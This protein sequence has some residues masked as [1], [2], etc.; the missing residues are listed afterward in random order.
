[1]FFKHYLEDNVY[2]LVIVDDQDSLFTHILSPL[3]PRA[4][5][6]FWVDLFNS[7][8]IIVLS[9]TR[10]ICSPHALQ[11]IVRVPPS[12]WKRTWLIVPHSGHTTS[13]FSALL[14]DVNPST[15]PARTIGSLI[16]RGS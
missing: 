10:L 4:Y 15:Y 5:A 2:G 11:K 14:N 7:M 3:E 6:S 8:S 16:S 12:F 1:M 9:K 13:L